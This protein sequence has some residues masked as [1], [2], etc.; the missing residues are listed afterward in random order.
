[1][2]E[3]CPSCN[4]PVF[5]EEDEA[6]LRC[7][8]A[9]C[10]AQLLRHLIH[11]TSRDAMDIE[12]LG[13]AV[14]EQLLQNGLISNIV[15]LY[16][17]DYEKVTLLERTG[18]KTVQNLKN[19]IENSK[20]ND[21]S[22]LIF[23]LGIRHIGSKAGKLLSEHF[24]TMEAILNAKSE[25]FEAIEGFGSILAKS[26]FEFFS[27]EDTREMLEKLEALG[28]N[29]KSLKEVKDNRFTG[30]TF[31]LTGT[32]PTYSRNEASEII[33]GFGGKTSS[34]VSKKTSYVLAGEEAGSK[35]DKANKLGVRIINEEEFNQ[36]IK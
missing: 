26:A 1:M 29:M 24:G 15:D 25:D 20:Q 14:L 5:R 8:N 10:P 28:L 13:P 9:E 30:L 22:K 36:M 6:V 12:G 33:E 21:L 19:A 3:F 16:N 23:A 17:L 4:S 11:F 18:E 34:S 27:L 32:L 35:L 7:T 2:P 31:V